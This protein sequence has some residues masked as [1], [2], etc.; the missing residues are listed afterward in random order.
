[1]QPYSLVNVFRV[2]SV[3]ASIRTQQ[4]V[5]EIGQA[6]IGSPMLIQF[7]LAKT[8]FGHFNFSAEAQGY[9]AFIPVSV[10]ICLPDDEKALT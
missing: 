2:P 5:N 9:N 7:L 4:Y 1:M 10:I 6:E 8:Q 3:E